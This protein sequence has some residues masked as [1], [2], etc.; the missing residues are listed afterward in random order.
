MNY[1]KPKLL[2]ALIFSLFVF[3]IRNGILFCSMLGAG[4]VFIG[5]GIGFEVGANNKAKEAITVF[6]NA[7][8]QSNNA[9]LDLG[10][11]PGGVMLRLSF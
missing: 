1:P 9:N 2:L 4:A 7:I 3:T 8:R 10:F 5:I 6:N 11:S